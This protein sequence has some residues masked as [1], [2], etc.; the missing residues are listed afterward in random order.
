LCS[1]RL[2]LVLSHVLTI[3]FIQLSAEAILHVEMT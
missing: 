1:L 2:S 3:Q